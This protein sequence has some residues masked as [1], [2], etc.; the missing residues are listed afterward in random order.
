MGWFAN[1]HDNPDKNSPDNEA[2]RSPKYWDKRE[3]KTRDTKNKP[4]AGDQHRNMDT[5][6][7]ENPPWWGKPDRKK[8]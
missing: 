8:K 3:N 1:P 6:N 5:K 7:P 2:N 4:K